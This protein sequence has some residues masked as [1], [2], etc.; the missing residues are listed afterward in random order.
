MIPP[1]FEYIRFKDDRNCTRRI[2]EVLDPDGKIS[3]AQ[4]S[5]KLKKLGLSTAPR[6]KMGDTNETLSANLNQLEGGG[7]A[8]VGNHKSVDLEKNLLVQHR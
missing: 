7:V 8:G 3:P 1:F 4:I 2:A 5:N 6:K